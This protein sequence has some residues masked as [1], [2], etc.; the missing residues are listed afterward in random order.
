MPALAELVLIRDI[1]DPDTIKA[2]MAQLTRERLILRALLKV[3]RD[4]QDAVER[5]RQQGDHPEGGP[6]VA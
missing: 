1:P 6:H 3:S 4:K 2:R 5:E